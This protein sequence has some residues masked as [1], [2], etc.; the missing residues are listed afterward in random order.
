MMQQVAASRSDIAALGK[1]SAQTETDAQQTESEFGALFQQA[2]EADKGA[3]P[4]TSGAA[5]TSEQGR[6]TSDR[7]SH[8]ELNRSRQAADKASVNS[9]G[10]DAE[11][12]TDAPERTDG[13][14]A[15]EPA[16]SKADRMTSIPVE[17]VTDEPNDG[18]LV[19]MKAL[20]EKASLQDLL[21]DQ[22]G[23]VDWLAY[24]DAVRKASG[25]AVAPE[26]PGDRYETLPVMPAPAASD[27]AATDPLTALLAALHGEDPAAEAAQFSAIEATGITAGKVTEHRA[28]K[29]DGKQEILPIMPIMTRIAELL[30]EQ[31]SEGTGAPASGSNKEALSALRGELMAALRQ[32][33]GSNETVNNAPLA[34]LTEGD[35]DLLLQVLQ[36]EVVQAAKDGGEKLKTLPVGPGPEVGAN[37]QTGQLAGMATA[38]AAKSLMQSMQAGS[39]AS[40]QQMT[41]ALAEKVVALLPPTASDQ[42]HQQVK[43]SIIGGIQEIQ[44]QLAQGR[45]PGIDLKALVTDALR[46]ANIPVTPHM[47]SQAEQQVSQLHM[48]LSSAQSTA[49]QVVSS[50]LVSTDAVIQENSQ[51]RSESTKAQAQADGLDKPV[52]ITKAEG[53]QQLHEK[54]RWMV[55]A[56]N[57]MAEIRLDPP[58]LGSMQVR[59]NVNGDTASVN[60]VVQS[61]Q[62]KD[63]LA[64]AAP[65]LRDMLAEQGIELG[66]S[67]VQQQG[68]GEEG[69]GDETDGQFA[70]RGQ[71]SDDEEEHT[72]IEQPITRESRG[73]IDYYA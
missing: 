19:D 32:N 30:G 51:V 26:K 47:L 14:S 15:A 46:D 34:N 57:P 40:Q 60:F 33:T 43:Q 35:A 23:E 69:T 38:D 59:V 3:N 12:V 41:E 67:F 22:Q 56:R 65:R 37:N 25:E 50:Q 64:D 49:A 42:Q 1:S 68:S 55:N 9:S 72:V 11:Y 17:P 20:P 73:G 54:I 21:N 6:Q 62:A 39:E 29:G 13:V 48:M 4:A 63:A 58:E 5:S 2:A 53:Q 16:E 70:G 61:Q 31:T 66:E 52:N 71:R 7:Q 10:E 8:Q 24:V 18:N 36:S 44:S 45:E 27:E 28:D